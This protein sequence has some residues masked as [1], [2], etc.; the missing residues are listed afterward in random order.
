MQLRREWRF[1]RIA[2]A[3]VALLGSVLVDATPSPAATTT[4]V[5]SALNRPIYVTAPAGD[6]RLFIVEQ[7]G[8]IK[9]LKNGTV[10]ATPFLDIDS[11]IPAISGN[12]ER[13]LLGLAFH[14]DYATNGYFWVYYT[15][16]AGQQVVARYTRSGGNP[17]QA[18]AASALIYLTMADPFSNHNGGCIQFGQDGYLY[19]GTGDGGSAGDPG[20]RAQNKLDLLGK[21]LRID[22]NTHPYSIPPSNPFVGNPAYSQEIWS[23]GLRNP[24]R[25]SFDRETGDM[26]VAD[27]GQNEWEEIDF[28]PAN[29]GGRNYG[30]RL[31]EGNHC[32]NPSSNCDDGDPVLTYPIYE[33]SHSVGCSITG[34]YVYRGAALPEFQ[35][36]YFFSDFC[37][38][39][40]WTFRYEG[41]NLTEFT[42]RTTELA[43]GGGLSIGSIGS[44]GEDG[45]GELYICDRGTGS[46]GEV[47]KIIPDPASVPGSGVKTGLNL[48]PSVPNPFTNATQLH[49]ALEQSG[50]LDVV[51][52]GANGR[53][54]RNLI[55]MNEQAG[56][57]S[58]VW[59]GRDDRGRAMP[60]GVYFIRAAQ[61]GHAVT[62]RVELVR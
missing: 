34:G 19:I 54:V 24:W 9:I 52:I 23:L 18:D 1:L 45:F 39:S 40:I 35:G 36:I 48:S 7:R 15:S 20:N 57:R 26:L 16:N 55:S 25:W 44:Y 27:V 41:G 58:V 30:W 59:D 28:E 51:V 22:V 50:P 8:V 14:P 29:T 53:T 43:P 49:L 4:R 62:Q 2:A 56:A 37:T 17:D 46:N 32:Y 5:A 61:N 47:F 60:S 12:D 6:D 13:G 31:T 11:L 38:P 10:L 42:D 21:M 3:A 33:F